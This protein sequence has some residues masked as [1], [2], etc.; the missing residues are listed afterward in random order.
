MDCLVPTRARGFSLIELLVSLAIMAL[1]ASVAMPLAQ[2]TVRRDKEFALRRALRDLRQ[3]IDA[4]KAAATDGRIAVPADQ[5]GYPPDLTALV[6]GIDNVKATDG[7]KLYFLR[8]LPRDPFCVDSAVTA[9]DTWGQ[10][11]FASPPDKPQRGSDVFDVY[12]LSE[13]SGLNGLPYKEW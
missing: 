3:G 6:D 10:R 13:Q 1:L 9:A 4:Y 7:R 8:K 2:T 11:S 12:S 5:N